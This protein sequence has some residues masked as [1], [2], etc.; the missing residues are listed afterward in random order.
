MGATFTASTRLEKKRKNGIAV[1][2]FS[3]GIAANVFAAL[4]LLCG[5]A[6]CIQHFSQHCR[7]FC[8]AAL[9]Y[10]LTFL[11]ALPLFLFSG[12]AATN[13]SRGIN[14]PFFLAF[15]AALPQSGIAASSRHCRLRGIAACI[16]NSG[17]AACKFICASLEILAQVD[18][19]AF[20]FLAPSSPW[21]AKSR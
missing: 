4:P 18:C 2:C 8:L 6:A 20:R 11:G 7:P 14:R 1:F 19:V 17:I 5:I 3:R 13:I 10:V 9:P 21:L 16:A 15:L 12:I